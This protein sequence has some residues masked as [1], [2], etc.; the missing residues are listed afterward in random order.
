MCQNY[1]I[2]LAKVP[3]ESFEAANIDIIVVGCGEWGIIKQYKGDYPSVPVGHF[4]WPTNVHLRGHWLPIPSLCRSHSQIIQGP[5]VDRVP[6]ASPRRRSQ[7]GLCWVCCLR[8]YRVHLGMFLCLD[9]LPSILI[10]CS[11]RALKSPIAF[12]KG[13]NIS[14]LGGDFVL[15]PGELALVSTLL[16]SAST[17][18]QEITVPSRHE[19]A[20]PPIVRLS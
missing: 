16:C 9:W 13:G 7:E 15:G 11:Q 1:L 14:Q 3:K 8:Y 20:G 19:C 17:I 18:F 10:P 2:E 5:R 12:F 4:F 6:G